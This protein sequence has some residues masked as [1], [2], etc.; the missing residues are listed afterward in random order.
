VIAAV[1]TVTGTLVLR[2][3]ESLTVIEQVPAA[4]GAT[5]TVAAPCAS[6]GIATVAIWPV[7]G[8]HVFDCANV[9]V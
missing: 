6:D 7:N 1:E 2:P 5:W 9:P 3:N 4:I 8:V